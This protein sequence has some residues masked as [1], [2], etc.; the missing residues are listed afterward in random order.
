MPKPKTENTRTHSK[1]H[2]WE[3]D[4]GL[5]LVEHELFGESVKHVE[6]NTNHI[7]IIDCSGSMY[8]DLPRLREQLKRKLPKMMR[9]GDT[10][11]LI[12]FSGRGEFGTLL[13]N[14]P[15]ATLTDLADVNKAIDRWLKPMGLTGFKEP[16]AEVTK[17]VERVAKKNKNP[18][19]LFFMSDGCD[20]QWPRAD[21]LKAVEDAA[22]KLAAAVFV[23]YGYYADR[24]LLSAMAEKAGGVH[25]H[26]DAF[27]KFEV[28]FE[29]ALQRRAVGEPRVEVTIE[30]DVI[31]GFAWSPS[32]DGDLVTYDASTGRAA[33]LPTSGVLYYLSPT[34]VGHVAYTVAEAAQ[35]EVDK[36]LLHVFY[37][38]YAA[39]S[40]FAVRMKPEVVFPILK[41]L[42]DVT[43]IEQ[44]A[45]CFGKQKY[46]E[47]ME[48]TK[49]AAFQTDKR[50]VKGRDP[51]K[52][53]ADDAFTVLDLLQIISADGTTKL[54]VDHADF[55]YSR[56]GRG[57]VDADEN[58]TADEQLAVEVIR[59]QMAG[60]KNVKKLK[61]YQA[62]IDAILA[63]KQTA[64]KFVADEAPDG[65]PIASLTW[66]GSSPNVSVLITKTG[67][68]D[69]S[70]RPEHTKYKIP[71]EFPAKVFRNLAIVAHGLVNVEK[72]PVTMTKAT[73]DTLKKA[74][75]EMVVQ[76]RTGRPVEEAVVVINL[77]PLPVIN[78]KMVKAVTAKELIELE[79]ALTKHKAAQKVY[80]AITEERFPDRKVA[81]SSYA[82]LYGDDGAAWLKDQGLTSYNG[83]QPPSTQAASKDFIVGKELDVKLKGMS[84]L[85][86]VKDVRGGKKTGAAAFMHDTITEVDAWLAKSPEKLHK[87]WLEGKTKATISEVRSLTYEATKIKW[88][89]L[90]GQV[91]CQEF[92]SLD[93][94]TLTVK[95]DGKDVV[96]TIE[97]RE[98][99]I[100]V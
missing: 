60:E 10:L 41:A 66:N 33:V 80:K 47:F 26:A 4:K 25:I 28:T 96:G 15:I 93:E 61:E 91:W 6:S 23:E 89:I 13:E 54:L 14:E 55:K 16:L 69:L 87:D 82:T 24:P 100:K 29:S 76:L 77:K 8:G 74:G 92:K 2:S 64:L 20:N 98:V 88:S 40:L 46:S 68:V 37:P 19:A 5:Y 86:S 35:R 57:R 43:F 67:K 11:S 56:I 79:Y 78:R 73:Y 39:L 49:L 34:P 84:T 70:S 94:N 59:S 42:G 63:T 1:Q 21:I 45:N 85:P 36:K 58:L 3:I 75:V 48:A 18:F 52:I 62:E 50:F 81:A 38:A 51:N 99:E 27:D 22:G 7:A 17:L 53:P 90:V 72:L 71:T 12:W 9:E 31:G 44:F 65:Y 83:F 97:L 30:G 95:I 32:T